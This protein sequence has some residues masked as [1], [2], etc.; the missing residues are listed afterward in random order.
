MPGIDHLVQK[1]ENN[2]KNTVEDI[3]H[4]GWKQVTHEGRTTADKISNSTGGRPSWGTTRH[5]NPGNPNNWHTREATRKK[6][7]HKPTQ[8]AL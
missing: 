6:A 7:K 5:K 3:D 1:I 2:R 8:R 4:P